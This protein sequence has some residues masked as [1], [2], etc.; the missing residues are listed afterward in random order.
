MKKLVI[1][2]EVAE[3]LKK[4][5]SPETV[6]MCDA[7]LLWCFDGKEPTLKDFANDEMLYFLWERIIKK[8]LQ[9]EVI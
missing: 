1:N 5:G 6:I 7:I 2:E 9:K 8:E 4:L 3:V